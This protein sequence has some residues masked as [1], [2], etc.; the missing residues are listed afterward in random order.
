MTDFDQFERRLGA[1]LRSDADRHVGPFEAESI[2]RAAIGGSERGDMDPPRSSARPPGRFGRRRDNTLLAAAALL[3]VGGALAVGSGFLRLPSIV[4]P[5]PAPSFAVLATVSPDAMTTPTPS[6]SL[7]P[8]PTALSLDLT[9]AQLP[10]VTPVL[11]GDADGAYKQ[12]PR[13][14]WID[15]RFVLAEVKSGEVRTSADGQDWQALQPGD[16]ARGYVDLLRGSFASWQDSHVGWWNPQEEAQ[17]ENC[18]NQPPITDRDVVQIVRPLAA[19]TSTTPFKGR[20]ESIGIGPM[21]IVA[22]VHSDLDWDAWV[23]KKLGLRTNNDWTCCVKDVTFQDG[24]LQIKLNNRPGLK[25]VWADEG[26]EPGDYQDR[27][28]G[29]YS[30]DGEHWT[31]MAPNAEANEIGSTLPTGGFGKVA[32]VSDGFIATGASPDGACPDQDGSCTGMWYSSDGLT[33]RLLGAAPF[34]SQELLPWRGG[35]LATDGDGHAELWTS[36]GSAELPIAAQLHGTVA[37]GP[38][39][40]VSIGDGQA[41]VSRDGIDYKVS[42]IPAQMVGSTVVVGDRT[43]LVPEI[44]AVDEFTWTWSLWLGTFEQ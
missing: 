39:G 36:D 4:P 7:S 25:V 14:A 6:A 13:L 18:T 35:V 23:T 8:S 22:Q 9:W 20:I 33:W 43:V 29:W 15:D 21:G 17:C 37:T 10:L 31:A 27:G 16:A 42:S 3:L 40:V 38:L 28:F 11:K 12:S 5:V 2:A 32:G 26:L 30:P 41:L 34:E 1:A 44:A 24:V 19:P